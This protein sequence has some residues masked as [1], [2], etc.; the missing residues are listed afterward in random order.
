M[1]HASQ[2]SFLTGGQ[3]DC[4]R[5][6]QAVIV[7]A[8]Q[9]ELADISAITQPMQVANAA[10]SRPLFDWQLV[11]VD[12]NPVKLSCG[13]ELTVNRQLSEIHRDTIVFVTGAPA[14]E[15]E[16]GVNL[17]NW[18]RR[19]YRIGNRFVLLNDMAFTFAKI[20]LFDREEIAIHWHQIDLFRELFP[21]VRAVDQ[22]YTIGRRISTST[23]SDATTELVVTLI[24]T[25]FGREIARR[26]Q[27]QLN[28]PVIRAPATPQNIPLARRYGTRNKTFLAVVERI[29]SGFEDDLSIQ[30]LGREFNI[31][32]RQLER[33]FSKYAGVSPLRFIKDCRLNKASQLLQV[34]DMGILDVAIACGF[35]SGSSFR[36]A[37]KQKFGVN[38]SDFVGRR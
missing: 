27:E 29:M 26:V 28:R 16:H 31:S 2:K 18:I 13:A 22:I 1:K 5:Q 12:A 23:C 17:V 33:Q 20:G 9:A 35:S 10:A 11:S 37:F 6:T 7:V 4:L 36:S 19:Q 21:H 25:A 3:T 30:E 34:T 14:K 32:Q 24:E 15:S 8:P 38:P